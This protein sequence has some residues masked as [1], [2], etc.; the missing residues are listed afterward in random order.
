MHARG[1]GQRKRRGTRHRIK[2]HRSLQLRKLRRSRQTLAGR[3]A[4]VPPSCAVSF[5]PLQ[6]V[7]YPTQPPSMFVL[8]GGIVSLRQTLAGRGMEALQEKGMEVP[9]EK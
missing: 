6:P 4:Y 3:A 7:P 1:M 2:T 5:P 8:G 9:T